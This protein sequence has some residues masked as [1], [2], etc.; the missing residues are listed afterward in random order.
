MTTSKIKVGS[1]IHRFGD[2]LAIVLKVPPGPH[3]ICYQVYWFSSP[4]RVKFQTSKFIEKECELV[5]P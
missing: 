5:V 1:I 4:R 2:G 3:S